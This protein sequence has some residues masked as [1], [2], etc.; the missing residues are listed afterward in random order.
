MVKKTTRK[1]GGAS[2]SLS[3]QEI[4]RDPM[5]QKALRAYAQQGSGRMVGRGWWENF[6]DF[7]KKNKVVSSGSK[8]GSMIAT[9]TGN[10]PLA[11]ALSGI[12]S[13]ASTLGFGKRGMKGG[14]YAQ[15]IAM[16]SSSS[17]VP[18]LKF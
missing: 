10:V 5:I 16:P 7:L 18:F 14:A 12:S 17:V 15:S 1:K 6:V 4:L 13:T 2:M 11:T 3:K 8:I 9:A